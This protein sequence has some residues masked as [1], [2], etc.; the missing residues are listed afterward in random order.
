MQQGKNNNDNSNNDEQ[1]G[2][3]AMA[4]QSRQASCV[5]HVIWTIEALACRV[6]SFVSDFVESLEVHTLEEQAAVIS[7]IQDWRQRVKTARKQAR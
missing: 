6:N 5:D 1:K 4:L 7:S 2:Q 3:H